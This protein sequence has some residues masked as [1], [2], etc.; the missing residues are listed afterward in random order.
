MGVSVTCSFSFQ[1]EVKSDHSAVG[2]C[3]SVCS[4]EFRMERKVLVVINMILTGSHGLR[5]EFQTDDTELSYTDQSLATPSARGQIARR[6]RMIAPDISPGDG[7]GFVR[8]L[9]HSSAGVADGF[10]KS[11]FST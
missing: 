9:E 10:W 5:N 2:A 3:C 6:Y 1:L 8:F 11:L 4:V 7:T